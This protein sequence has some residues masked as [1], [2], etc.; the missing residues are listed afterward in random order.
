[1][2]FYHSLKLFL[3][4]SLLYPEINLKNKIYKDYFNPRL[5]NLMQSLHEKHWYFFIIGIEFNFDFLSIG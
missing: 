1:M 2:P 4:I 5:T 3:F